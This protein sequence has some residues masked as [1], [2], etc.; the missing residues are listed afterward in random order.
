MFREESPF[1]HLNGWY[2]F[3]VEDDDELVK[4]PENFVILDG[5]EIRGLAPA[6]LDIYNAA[7]GTEVS[8]IYE[9]GVH[10]G[11]YDLKNE[12]MTTVEEILGRRYGRE[13]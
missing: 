10:S 4:D 2:L 8:W 3:A 12:C 9:E 6:V 13:G 11:F 5:A 7:F 1:V